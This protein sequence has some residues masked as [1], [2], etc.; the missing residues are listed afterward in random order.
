V[1]KAIGSALYHLGPIGSGAVVKLSANALL[2]V[3]VTVFAELIR[4]LRRTG[5]DAGNALQAIAGTAVWSPVAN[6]LL[7]SMLTGDFSPQFPVELI[8]KDFSYTLQAAGSET[9]APMIA[10][11]RDVFRDANGA[12]LGGFNMTAVLELIAPDN[13]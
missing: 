3:Q 12:G 8:E 2:G 11:A 6:Y 5:A 10:T 9:A 4:L 7:G 13:G 1:L